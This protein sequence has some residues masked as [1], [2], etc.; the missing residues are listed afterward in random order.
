MAVWLAEGKSVR[1]MADARGHTE[2]AIYWHL[3]RIYQKHSISPQ[4]DLVRLVLSLA[5]L[6]RGRRCWPFRAVARS[7][8]PPAPGERGHVSQTAV[9]DTPARTPSGARRRVSYPV[10][11]S[12][13]CKRRARGPMPC[14]ELALWSEAGWPRGSPHWSA[15]HVHRPGLISRTPHPP[16]CHRPAA[17]STR[18]RAGRAQAVP[19]FAAWPLSNRK[20]GFIGSGALQSP[21]TSDASLQPALLLRQIQAVFLVVAPY[22]RGASLASMRRRAF[23]TY[24]SEGK[25]RE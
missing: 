1:D 5:E 24:C 17:A 19:G 9:C 15:V 12:M 18:P 10:S 7:G 25:N 23:T 20:S 21:A 6:G 16:D 3:Q 8:R 11:D 2:A 13:S 4:A 14:A 22:P